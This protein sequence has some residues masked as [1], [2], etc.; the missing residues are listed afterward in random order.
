ML[1][2]KVRDARRFQDQGVLGRMLSL[3]IVVGR[4]AAEAS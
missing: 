3:E 2:G 4:S 1:P